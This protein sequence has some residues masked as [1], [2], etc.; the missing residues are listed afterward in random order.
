MIETNK[1]VEEFDSRDRA[2]VWRITGGRTRALLG[3]ADRYVPDLITSFREA[4]ADLMHRA[5]P[6]DLPTLDAEQQRLEHRLQAYGACRDSPAI[7]T[8]KGIAEPDQIADLSDDE[9]ADL[10]ASQGAPHD[11]R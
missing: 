5:T 8:A 11:A 10:L 2:L 3:V 4:A 9:F 6:L 1:G 7:W